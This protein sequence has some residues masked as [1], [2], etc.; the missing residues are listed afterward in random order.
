MINKWTFLGLT[1]VLSALFVA[2]ACSDDDSDGDGNGA[3]ASVCD[4]REDSPAVC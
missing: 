1:L 2:A 3:T 4:E